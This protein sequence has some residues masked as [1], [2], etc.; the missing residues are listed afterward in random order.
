M[1]ENDKSN[2]NTTLNPVPFA[3]NAQVFHDGTLDAARLREQLGSDEI[4]IEWLLALLGHPAVAPSFED[5]ALDADVQEV[6]RDALARAAGR[7]GVGA[8]GSL[9]NLRVRIDAR[10]QAERR[11]YDLVR[12][13][14]V[15]RA[16]EPS[17]QVELLRNYLGTAPAPLFVDALGARWPDLLAQASD[18]LQRGVDLAVLLE[19][20]ALIQQLCAPQAVDFDEILRRLRARL[21]ALNAQ[22]PGGPEMVDALLRRALTT[23]APQARLMGAALAAVDAR[24]DLVADILAVFLAAGPHSPQ[25]AVMAAHLDPLITRN[26]LAQFLVDVAYQNPEEPEAEL[27]PERM[28]AIVSARCTLPLIGSPLEEMSADAFP[29][30]PDFADLRRIQALVVESWALWESVRTA[31]SP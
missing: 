9:P 19:D 31:T 12:D 1:P 24:I 7:V 14:M 17:R 25:L 13:H 26:A 15:R 20:S 5:G 2:E 10:L 16:D 28:Q 22:V 27:T 29:D 21:Q 30:T 4:D 3:H 23:G 11:K 6:L 18:E 8:Y